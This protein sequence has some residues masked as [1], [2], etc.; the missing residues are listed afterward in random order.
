MPQSYAI[1]GSRTLA[2]LAIS[3]Q[4]LIVDVGWEWEEGSMEDTEVRMVGPC[5]SPE[6]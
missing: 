1:L 2:L 6:W 3:K 4:A 5:V